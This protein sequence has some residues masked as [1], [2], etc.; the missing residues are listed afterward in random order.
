MN[1][2]DMIMRIPLEKNIS[3]QITF[4]LL[5]LKRLA[6]NENHY[7]INFKS[8]WINL[9][10]LN[11]KEERKKYFINVYLPTLQNTQ[12]SQNIDLLF[13]NFHIPFLSIDDKTLSMLIDAVEVFSEENFIEF[14]LNTK[15]EYRLGFIKTLD[16]EIQGNITKIL[17]IKDN[18]KVLDLNLESSNFLSLLKPSSSDNIGFIQNQQTLLLRFLELLLNNDENTNLVLSNPLHSYS[19]KLDCSFDA[20]FTIPIFSQR[21]QKKEYDLDF[22]IESSISHN[23]YIQKALNSL[24]KDGKCAFI[25]PDG[26][27]TQLNK[28]TI[29]LRK[30]ILDKLVCTINL[31]TIF[32]PM[33]GIKVSLL[34][35]KNDNYNNDILML[36]YQNDREFPIKKFTTFTEKFMN[37][38]Y[39]LKKINLDD[40]ED[41]L[42]VNKEEIINNQFIIDFNRYKPLEDFITEI[43]NPSTLINTIQE[44]TEKVINRVLEI[45]NKLNSLHEIKSDI[46]Q[47]Q[48]EDF[49][50]LIQGKAL[51]KCN[52]ENGEISYINISDITKC[53]N[54]YIYTSEIQISEQFAYE[55]DLTIVEPNSILLSIRGTIGKAIITKK[56]VVIS[57]TLIAINVDT[58]KVNT[59]FI[60]Q[61]F[62]SNREYLESNATGSTIPSLNMSFLKN[63]KI[64]LPSKEIQ[65]KFESYQD[66]LNI[67]KNSLSILEEANQDLSKSIFKQFY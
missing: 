35:L 30:L 20:I 1:I 40:I 66:D 10:K 49:A 24:K 65:D 9:I 64:E 33:T 16:K 54:D 8:L 11:T 48:I 42:L 25:I 58:S 12:I 39:D 14:I 5:I 23:L 63:L 4:S 53:R 31:G 50:Q 6:D 15:E 29:N 67:V 46:N 18:D 32:K 57:S 55:N 3:Y 47:Y 51:P 28:E 34:I 13:R 56:K 43:E 7:D 41:Q 36:N 45:K 38:N 61:W 19:D 2:N 62:L 21:L 52:I 22:P 37:C 17:D 26:F 59:Y 60:Y 44:N 27:L